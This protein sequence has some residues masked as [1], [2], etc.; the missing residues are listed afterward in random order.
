MREANQSAERLGSVLRSAYQLLKFA[1]P[2]TWTVIAVPA[3]IVITSI[4]SVLPP[5]LIGHMIDALQRHDMQA[6]LRLLTYYVLLTGV[7]GV[8]RLISGYCT[9]VFRETTARN[10]RLD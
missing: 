5:L 2:P 4:V 7:F 9:N 10:L 8:V 1:R 3:I 6:T